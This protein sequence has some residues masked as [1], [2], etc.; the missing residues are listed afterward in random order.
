MQEAAITFID[1]LG[2]KGIWQREPNPIEKVKSVLT[3][4][5]KLVE[6]FKENDGNLYFTVA[7]SI[8][9]D[10]K[11]EVLS[12]SDTIVFI[13]YGEC[14]AALE[15]Q[16]GLAI[17]TITSFLKINLAVRGAICY[18]KLQREDNVFM[19]PAVDEIA[20]WYESADWIGVFLTPSALYRLQYNKITYA[21]N[22]IKYPVPLKS[23]GKFKTYCVNWIIAI[24]DRN[25]VQSIFLN[26]GP[27]TPELAEKFNN[28]LDYFDQ[29]KENLDYQRKKEI[30]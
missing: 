13:T 16:S 19:G 4:A 23:K 11:T 14:N 22:F 7:N 29:M 24:E 8:F 1:I 21:L 15:F 25:L 18:G 10:L 27:I 28:T 26:M 30:E 3:E 6:V 17:N 2:W 9:K 5:L 12:I 20:A